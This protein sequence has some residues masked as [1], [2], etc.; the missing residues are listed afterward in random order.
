[1]S[2]LGSSPCDVG[3]IAFASHHAFL[4]ELFSLDELPH[5]RIVN[6][7]PAPSELGEQ[8]AQGEVSLGSPRYG[9]IAFRP[10][11]LI[12]PDATLP[13]CAAAAPFQWS[14]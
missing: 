6:L 7:Q 11:S 1:L 8:A 3:T 10:W 14:C 4:T 13:V 5:R 12:S 2:L 9:E